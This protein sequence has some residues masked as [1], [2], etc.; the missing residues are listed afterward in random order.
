MLFRSVYGGVDALS[1]TFADNQAGGIFEILHGRNFT[2]PGAF[3]NEGL[4]DVGTGSTMTIDGAFANTGSLDINGTLV[5]QSLGIGATETLAGSGTIVGDVIVYGSTDP[6]NSPGILTVDGNYSQET[7]SF[8]NIQ[9]GGVSSGQFDQLNVTGKANLNGLLLV[10]LFDGF[11]PASGD[12]FPMLTY[13]SR[14]GLF[15]SQALPGGMSLT[16]TTTAANLGVTGP[17]S[18][19]PMLL[20]PG[21]AAGKMIFG[22]WTASGTNYTLYRTDSLKPANWITITNF[23]GD[24]NFWNFSLSMGSVSNRFYRVS[25]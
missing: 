5:A 6:G 23:T 22:V 13:G 4:L 16:Y 1:S 7:G 9:L 24:G 11:P 12:S 25:R 10:H 15:N 8:L 3:S 17:V 14:S 20:N 2:T 18:V 19:Q 21:I